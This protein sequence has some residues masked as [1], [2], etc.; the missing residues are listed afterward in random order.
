M[1]TRVVQIIRSQ[2]ELS[3]PNEASLTVTDMETM[4]K[5]AKD[6]MREGSFLLHS[7]QVCTFKLHP[8]RKPIQMDIFTK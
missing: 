7:G 4:K 3:F 8:Y 6:K 1:K 2:Y 5:C